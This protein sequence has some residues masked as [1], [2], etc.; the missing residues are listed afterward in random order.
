MTYTPDKI[1]NEEY[2]QHRQQ[3][4]ETAE[5][6]G[7]AL[8][9]VPYDDNRTDKNGKVLAQFTYTFGNQQ[10][11]NAELLSFYPSST[12]V[13]FVLNK[14]SKAL[15]EGRLP[16]PQNHRE[17]VFVDN[18]I[19]QSGSPVMYHALDADQ[20]AFANEHYTCQY[21]DDEPTPILHV[22]IPA[23]NGNFFPVTPQPLMP[24]EEYTTVTAEYDD[25]KYPNPR[26]NYVYRLT[27][28]PGTEN[29]GISN[30]QLTMYFIGEVVADIL[31]LAHLDAKQKG[32][33]N[34]CLSLD[35][36]FEISAEAA[37]KTD[38]ECAEM[39]TSL[40]QENRRHVMGAICDNSP[41]LHFE[42]DH[43]FFVEAA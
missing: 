18:F 33:S 4:E 34:P 39:I 38:K 28:E 12:T 23:P 17:I 10:T 27:Q 36:A 6:H 29:W 5:K 16:Y 26:P 24:T 20:R 37:A 31:L 41:M 21:W 43:I 19:E 7:R 40:P 42:N 32:E 11:K 15:E 3:L 25:S 8:I 14:L 22:I 1:T 9:S 2:L 13:C 35:L 30:L